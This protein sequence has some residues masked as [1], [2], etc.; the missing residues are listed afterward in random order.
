MFIHHWFQIV[1]TYISEYYIQNSLCAY[2]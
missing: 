2:W 1:Y